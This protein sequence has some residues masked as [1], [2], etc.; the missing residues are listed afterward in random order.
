MISNITAPGHLH[1]CRHTYTLHFFLTLRVCLEG[2]SLR[3]GDGE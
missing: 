3:E 2:R 1:A